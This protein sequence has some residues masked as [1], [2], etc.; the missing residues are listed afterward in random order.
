[1]NEINRLYPKED[2]VKKACEKIHSA[3]SD[4]LDKIYSDIWEMVRNES[5]ETRASLAVNQEK[6]QVSALVK[7]QTG[8]M[9]NIFI[10]E[11][12]HVSKPKHA[13]ERAYSDS[14]AV[15][16]WQSVAIQ[17]DLPVLD[18]TK[19][20]SIG[21]YNTNMSEEE[22]IV[23]VLR[24]KSLEILQELKQSGVQ[25]RRCKEVKTGLDDMIY[26]ADKTHTANIRVRLVE[27]IRGEVPEQS[28]VQPIVSRDVLK[29]RKDAIR[30]KLVDWVDSIG[31][32]VLA[33]EPI[34]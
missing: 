17:I 8:G 16:M 25:E 32:M 31:E 30:S 19:I 18:Y 20:E 5:P 21:N 27:K 3:F 7:Q 15:M 13:D 12:C 23:D 4:G 2:C 28:M 24:K 22:I 33:E 34:L 6:A 26:K 29:S 1:M 11:L 10:E 9:R 14:Q